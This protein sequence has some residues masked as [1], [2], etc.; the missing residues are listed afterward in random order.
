VTGPRRYPETEDETHV[1]GYRGSGADPPRWSTVLGIVI[2][3]L[4]VLT[5]VVLHL[6]G[7]IG[8]GVHE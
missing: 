1:E 7:V 3:I 2:P 8:P 4:V 6:T 5:L